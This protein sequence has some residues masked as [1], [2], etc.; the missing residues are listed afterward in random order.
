MKFVVR[1]GFVIH[2]TRLVKQGEKT[3]EQTNSYFEGDDVDFDEATAQRHL[4]KLEPNDK[5]ATAF[6]NARHAP[7][8][9]APVA[10]GISTELLAELVAQGVA[11]A[12][13][14][15]AANTTSLTA[16]VKKPS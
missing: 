12:L 1:E 2:D 13:A 10:S 5:A 14:S 15:F 16:E 9:A 8:S 7:V 11:A 6:V 4:H 3:V